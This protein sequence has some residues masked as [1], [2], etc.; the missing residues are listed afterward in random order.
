MENAVKQ[1]VATFA[2]LSGGHDIAKNLS[3]EVAT[4]LAHLF[5][6]YESAK[7]SIL[8]NALNSD[9]LDLIH[10]AWLGKPE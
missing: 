10:A 6:R 9:M 8:A 3:L 2:Q 4:D 1:P 5:S 7:V